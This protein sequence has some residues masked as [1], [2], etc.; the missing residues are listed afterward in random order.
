M[1]CEFD[2]KM[3]LN[4]QNI[5]QFWYPASTLEFLLIAHV[6]LT[7]HGHTNSSRHIW[8]PEHWRSRLTLISW[9]RPNC[10][11]C[12]SRQFVCQSGQSSWWSRLLYKCYTF[13][14]VMYTF[15]LGVKVLFIKLLKVIFGLWVSFRFRLSYF[16]FYSPYFLWCTPKTSKI[17]KKITL[18]QHNFFQWH[19]PVE[20]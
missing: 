4:A 15:C 17:P 2:V 12:L 14:P 18:L 16:P 1:C 19:F 8:Y 6:H 3:H 13:F 5:K 10:L 11:N 20:A 9:L 7:T